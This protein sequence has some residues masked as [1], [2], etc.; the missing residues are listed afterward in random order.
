MG[1][2]ILCLLALGYLAL[3]DFWIHKRANLADQRMR[4]IS[5]W[6]SQPDGSQETSPDSPDCQSGNIQLVLTGH[7]Y[8][9]PLEPE[10]YIDPFSSQQRPFQLTH[11][12][13][14]FVITSCGPD[15]VMTLSSETACQYLSSNRG[16]SLFLSQWAYSPTNGLLSSGDLIRYQET[17]P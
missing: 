16:Q 2:V 14:R 15:Q 13:S 12:G 4:Q 10:T 3:H 6:L 11:L 5:D 9:N 17:S 7:Q 1:L 8:N